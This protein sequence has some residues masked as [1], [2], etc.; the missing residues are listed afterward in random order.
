MTVVVL[1]DLLLLYWLVCGFERTHHHL[2][3][4]FNALNCLRI[5]NMRLLSSLWHESLFLLFSKI[6]NWA[7]SLPNLGET[8]TLE[9][10]YDHHFTFETGLVGLAWYREWLLDLVLWNFRDTLNES[11]PKCP[12]RLNAIII[13]DSWVWIFICLVRLVMFNYLR[14]NFRRVLKNNDICLVL[15]LSRRYFRR[16]WRLG[17]D[18]SPGRWWTL[19]QRC[20]ILN[21]RSHGHL[22]SI[23]HD[24]ACSI[25]Q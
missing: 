19:I 15:L 8:V 18:N 21:E 12:R 11:W 2:W 1:L 9:V 17:W 24:F 7:L 5:I 23:L 22:V 16:D 4:V 10:L 20:D 3:L 14:F 25:C 6:T 13:W